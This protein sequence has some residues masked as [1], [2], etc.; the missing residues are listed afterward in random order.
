MYTVFLFLEEHDNVFYPQRFINEHKIL[1]ENKLKLSW[2][3]ALVLEGC[4]VENGDSKL[5]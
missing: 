2:C 4:F 5:L 1:R 3:Q